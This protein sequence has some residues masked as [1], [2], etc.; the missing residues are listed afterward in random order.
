MSLLHREPL[1]EPR[2]QAVAG[3][4][5]APMPG[6]VL[7]VSVDAGEQVAA[8]AEVLVLEAM[9]MEH[10]V[11]APEAGTVTTVAV[12]QGDQVPAGAVLAVVDPSPPHE[13]EQ[14]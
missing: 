14:S 9:K 6:A 7:R 11:L 3:A 5:V 10:R 1:P 8:G 13:Q 12:A 4:M 2:P